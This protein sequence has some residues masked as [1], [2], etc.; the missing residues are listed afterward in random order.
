M[1]KS[2]AILSV[3]ASLV[4]TPRAV[5]AIGFLETLVNDVAEQTKLTILE[6]ATPAYFYDARN[7]LSKAGVS[8]SIFEYR[9]IEADAGWVT[10]LDASEKGAAV[11]G[12]GVRVDK[13]LDFLFPS[14]D[15]VWGAADVGKELVPNPA[16]RFWKRLAVGFF[17]GHDFDRS[18]VIYGPYAGLNYKF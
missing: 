16:W 12:G 2:L 15:W 18:Q 11:L 7:G 4:V 1:K 6:S 9:F 13:L 14:T 10:P 8:T 3:L 17:T 5:F